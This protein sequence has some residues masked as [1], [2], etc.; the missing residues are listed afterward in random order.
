MIM[1][2]V[3]L[4]GATL[5]VCTLLLNAQNNYPTF[6]ELPHKPH[7]TQAKQIFQEL[8][9]LNDADALEPSD[10]FED[11]LGFT[12]VTYQQYFKGV[13]VDGAT[14]RLHIKND[15]IW[16]M[17][18]HYFDIDPGLSATPTW[19]PNA[20]FNQAL[21]HVGANHYVWEDYGSE[22]E[23]ELVI[24]VDRREGTVPR[25]THKFDIYAQEP[26]Y[27]A[28]VY[29][30]A[31]TGKFLTEDLSIHHTQV[32]ASGVSLYNGTVSFK[33]DDYGPAYRLRQSKVQ[34]FDMNNGT[35]HG[36]ATDVTSNTPHFT[37]DPT[38]VQ[39]HWGAEQTY[40]YF[41]QEH[42]R[43]SFDGEG[44]VIRSY[45]HYGS[46]YNNAFWD[47]LRMTYGDGD[48]VNY[49]PLVSIDI[50]AHEITHGVTD[51]SADLVY[52]YESGALN[53]SFSDIF[54][55]VIERYATGTNDWLMAA[56]IKLTGAPAIRSMKN[57]KALGDPDTYKG[58][59]WYSGSADNGGVHTN[60]GVQNKWFYILSE[61]ETGVND[62]GDSYSV[63]GIGIDKA[64]AIAYRNLTVYLS[65]HSDYADAR[66]GAIQ[67]AI[68]LYGEGSAEVLA[69]T[70]AWY[71]VGLG[72]SEGEE[73]E[74]AYC[75]SAGSNSAYEWIA[76]VNI[77]TFSNTS[78]AAGYT[79]FTS[80][81]IAVNAGQSYN[82]SL[83][84]DFGG[85]E[86][87][88]YWRIWI[89]YNGDGDFNDSGELAFDAGETSSSTVTGTIQ[90]PAGAN[91]TTRLRV[92]MKYNESAGPCENFNYGE[93]E[94]YTINIG[95]GNDSDTQAPTPPGAL[96]VTN[97]TPSSANL[98]W[99]AASDNV[100]VV[101]YYV[102]VNGSLVGS[103][104]S[105]SYALSGLNAGT[106][107]TVSVT[108]GDAA[109][110]ESNP[111]TI[112]VT[113]PVDDS[114]GA[115]C[116]AQGNNAGSE[117][118]A[119]VSVGGFTNNSGSAGYSDFTSRII[120]LTAGQS[121]SIRLTPGF[122]S[123]AYN[124]R[125]RIWIDFNAD[126]DFTDP[127]EQVFD[128]GT[129]RKT[130]V[131]G[132]IEIPAGAQ[133]ETRLRVAMRYNA[134]PAA[135]GAFNYGEVEDYTI[136]IGSSNEGDTTPPTPPGNLTA[137]NTTQTA[138]TLSWNASTDNVG[139]AGYDVYVNGA[140]AGT[141]TTTGYTLTGLTPGTTYTVS[142]VAKDAAGNQSSPATTNVS[143]QAESPEGL[144]CS[145]QGNN[146]G[147]EWIVGV[148]VGDFSH[149][150]G[151]A[152][153]SDFTSLT[154]SLTAG[155][156]YNLT[157]T[158]GFSAA[159]YG[160]YWR[161]WID[162]N[163]DGD[164]ADSGELAFDAGSTD[165]N[166]VTG[167]LVVPT[168][169]STGQTRM[170]VAM[171]YNSAPAPCGAFNY[172]EVEDY[173]VFINT[174]SGDEEDDGDEGKGSSLL[175]AHYFEDGWDGWSDGGGDC[176]RY[177]GP[178]SW[179]GDY[180]I[181]LRDNSGL[182]SSM[183][184]ASYN[185]SNYTQLKISFSFYASS[186]EFGEELR[187]LFF[188]GS[189]WQ[190]IAVLSSGTS[191][192]ND[193][194]NHASI[195]LNNSAYNFPANAR[196]RFQCNA[197]SNQDLVYIDAVKVT[198]SGLAAAVIAD[199][200]ATTLPLPAENE[201]LEWQETPR[202][203]TG[204]KQ[205][206]LNLALFPNPA[207]DELSIDFHLP[208]ATSAQIILTT[209]NGQVLRRQTLAAS[210]GSQRTTLEVSDLPG[211]IYFVHLVTGTERI[212]RKV[213]V[214]K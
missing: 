198:A 99:S 200:E 40:Q 172:G 117:W 7:Q 156:S 114:G 47:G 125:W 31:H 37:N 69:T 214:V 175:F 80:K 66:T 23:P 26:L 67:A 53:E 171:R 123:T 111:R 187:L 205:T 167:A 136:V 20:S 147:A 179:E 132:A 72:G 195:T 140:F 64:A 177:A 57:P 209:L 142:V 50:V 4:S 21:D 118:I 194:F 55:E 56:E 45:V 210:S 124:E 9:N 199:Q 35:Y 148:A 51:H 157:L 109:G 110:N 61:G 84:P 202:L 182:A 11:P 79:D 153:Y 15:R 164:F 149:T 197:S 105:R 71:A 78:G 93:V 27:R 3:L 207:S 115:Y 54:G 87:G 130:A 77:G 150:S 120:Q 42:G 75:A 208:A 119:G 106:A 82:L 76:K 203:T 160:E 196:F 158:P 126:G 131:T 85:G 62:N 211:G 65:A 193:I 6:V 173:S 122:L 39:A 186:M 192:N 59:Y 101:R 104:T 112:T 19:S 169:A 129:A 139:V 36:G 8:F 29:I 16:Y 94:D 58:D 127:G 10:I 161:I 188:D 213:A 183:T 181:R 165:K 116:G 144:Y 32:D 98:S 190:N 151:S 70:N 134:A 33:A 68:D 2:T 185:V 22:P 49:T 174:G 102:Y 212:S 17:S 184:S 176:Y 159:E 121:H 73:G 201:R 18:G 163:Q 1:K 96:T 91:G 168:N 30:D 89:D 43:N 155:Q 95:G 204:W 166:T 60:S 81:T 13:K 12:H 170:R 14:Y 28:F 107:Y 92:S 145:A 88:E 25:L 97:V 191:F 63:N 90:I 34:T 113:T 83:E 38:A 146:A 180:S 41:L 178:Y 44:S 5:F 133:G 24:L 189:Q 206:Q 52:A 48:G 141:T 162:Y 74:T 135:C 143:T 46:K 128:S 103:T 100:G 108:A 86:F 154:V 152:G 138:T 137:G